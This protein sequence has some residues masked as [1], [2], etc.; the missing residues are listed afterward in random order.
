M[1][2]KIFVRLLASEKIYLQALFDSLNDKNKVDEIVEI[3]YFTLLELV[4]ALELKQ[5][6]ELFKKGRG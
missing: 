6:Y 3:R 4:E 2:H 5:E 1:K